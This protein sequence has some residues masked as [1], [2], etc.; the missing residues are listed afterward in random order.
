LHS[1]ITAQ[2][3]EEAL[4]LES[5]YTE[6]SAMLVDI[7]QGIGASGSVVLLVHSAKDKGVVVY[8]SRPDE[9]DVEVGRIPE[10]LPGAGTK[11]MAELSG[12]AFI[13][14]YEEVGVEN[15][16]RDYPTVEEMIMPEFVAAW[17]ASA[18]EGRLPVLG[19]IVGGFYL[20]FMKNLIIDIWK[21]PNGPS[22]A[23]TTVDGVNFAVIERIFIKTY[24]PAK[25]LVEAEIFGRH[26]SLKLLHTE[27]YTE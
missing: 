8:V 22:W 24:D 2:A 1:G 19:K 7:R 10:Y 14:Q 17:P 26:P 18:P 6:E 3:A 20:P 12:E 15:A 16:E 21:V 13:E 25:K 4:S 9:A 27:T 5:K 23:T 11:D